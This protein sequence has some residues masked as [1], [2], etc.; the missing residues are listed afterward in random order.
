MKESWRTK[1]WK[2]GKTAVAEPV[3][4]HQPIHR[5]WICSVSAL[6]STIPLIWPS[7]SP[8]FLYSI[9]II[10]LWFYYHLIFKFNNPCSSVVR[11]DDYKVTGLR[12]DP[13][14]SKTFFSLKIQIKFKNATTIINEVNSIWIRIFFSITSTILTEGPLDL[15]FVNESLWTAGLG[16]RKRKEWKWVQLEQM[17]HGKW[18]TIDVRLTAARERNSPEFTVA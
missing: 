8:S 16:Q 12:F 10:H 4:H 14:G 3:M 15:M 9:T 13:N 5:R 7:F 18:A 17:V 6:H 11:D 1:R 2:A